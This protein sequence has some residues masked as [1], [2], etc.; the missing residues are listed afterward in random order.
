MPATGAI[1]RTSVN[2]RSKAHSRISAIAH[3]GFLILV[4]LVLGPVISHIPTAALGAVL[5]GTSYRIARPTSLK[6]LLRTTRL[7]ASTLLITA[8][9]VV[10]IGLI[11]AIILSVAGYLLA[12]VI[13]ERVRR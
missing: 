4:V 10:I 9:L 5:I 13:L 7:D 6:E 2:I 11:W 1:A 8:A 12:T 3:S